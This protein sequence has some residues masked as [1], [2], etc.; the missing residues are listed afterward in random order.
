[1]SH[2]QE[3]AT[4]REAMSAPTAADFDQGFSTAETSAGL[5]R[6]WE[7]AAPA[8]PLCRSTPSTSPPTRRGRRGTPDPPPRR[9]AGADQL[10]AEV[11]RRCQA[12]GQVADRLGAAPARGGL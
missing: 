9:A 7:L 12:A 6:V 8:T 2:D 10:A 11:P 3:D 4:R 1:M 5:R